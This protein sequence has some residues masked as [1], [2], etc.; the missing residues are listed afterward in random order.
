[1]QIS[2][3]FMVFATV[4]QQLMLNNIND[5]FRKGNLKNK[6]TRRLQI[7]ARNQEVSS[8]FNI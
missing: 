7:S 5:D 1:M 6:I 8:N 4:N 2:N 3:S